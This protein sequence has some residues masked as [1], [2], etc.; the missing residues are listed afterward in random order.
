MGR[1]AS[2]FPSLLFR[3]SDLISDSTCGLDMKELFSI[4]SIRFCH[5][6][7]I[8]K[9][10]MHEASLPR[11][12][13]G[14]GN[15]ERLYCGLVCQGRSSAGQ[16]PSGV[17][18]KLNFSDKTISSMLIQSEGGC[19]LFVQTIICKGWPDVPPLIKADLQERFPFRLLERIP[20]QYN[21][22]QGRLKRSM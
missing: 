20:S 12:E 8:Q 18:D 22:R 16:F 14:G 9:M 17:R 10:F 5:P 6:A 3:R 2:Q 15:A 7:I 11:V 1:A 4:Q 13:I 21:R 19:G